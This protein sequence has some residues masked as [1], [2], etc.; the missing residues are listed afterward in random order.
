MAISKVI[1]KSSPSATPVTWMDVTGKTVTSGTMLSGTTALKND[2]TDITGNIASK[3]SSDLTASGATVTAPAGYYASNASTSICPT[4]TVTCDSD[5]QTVQSVV[6][7]KTF[8]E[9]VS[10]ASDDVFLAVVI[11][12]NGTLEYSFGASGNGDNNSITY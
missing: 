4:F 1:Y 11:M 6:C 10:Y 5:F 2:G 9:C 12:D 8:A 7:D 3:S